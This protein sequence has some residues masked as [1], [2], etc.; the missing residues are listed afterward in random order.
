ML[1]RNAALTSEFD[2]QLAVYE[3]IALQDL[4]QPS[5]LVL[6]LPR[7]VGL[8]EGEVV[9]IVCLLRAADRQGPM[10]DWAA[11]AQ[12]CP[13]APD[14]IAALQDAINIWQARGLLLCARLDKTDMLQQ[15]RRHVHTGRLLVVGP[16]LVDP[17]PHWLR[18]SIL[19]RT[20]QRH[21]MCR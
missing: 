12:A 3:L 11:T 13:S 17:Y 18:N 5:P 4:P 14:C 9:I 7:H 16:C 8:A 1:K 19:H 6:G 20:G 21:M 10:L 2:I 15:R